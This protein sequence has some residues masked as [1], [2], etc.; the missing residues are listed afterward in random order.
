MDKKLVSNSKSQVNTPS[1]KKILFKN[2]SWAIVGKIMQVINGLLIGVV[3]ARYLKPEQ[4]GIL[5]YTLG[6]VALFPL[7]TEFGLNSILSR[8]LAKENSDKNALMGTGIGMRLTLSVFTIII[9]FFSLLLFENNKTLRLYIMI[10]SVNFLFLSVAMTIRNYFASQLKNDLIVKSEIFRISVLAVVKIVCIIIKAPLIVFIGLTAIDAAVIL[11]IMVP[12]FY[13]KF[14]S[15][16]DFVYK[17]TLVKTLSVSSTPL[18]IEGIA[19]IFYQRIDVVLAGRF[20]STEAVAYYSVALKFIDFAVFIPLAIVQTLS[21]M[22]VRKFEKANYNPLDKEYLEF[23][24]KMGDIVTYAGLSV[25]IFLFLAAGPLVTILYGAEY[26]ESVGILRVLA[27]KGLFCGLG[28][29][30]SAMIIAEGRQKYI[31]WTN[32]IGC[33]I[34]LALSFLLIPR[35]GLYGVAFSTIISFGIGTY[36]ANYLI[37][38]YKVD[39]RFQSEF[40]LRGSGRIVKYVKAHFSKHSESQKM[41]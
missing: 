20:I 3:V 24:R 10:S 19:S 36:F 31:Y 25:S 11:L 28:Y 33:V 18:F 38:L 23:K 14:G 17:R 22:L 13:R 5:N 21:A 26:E 15:F 32:I 9:I 40:L 1:N 7:L 6:Y 29:S 2:V 39:F 12:I 35:Y 30:A 41:L 8:E 16:K 34:N 27:W 37:P 4:Y